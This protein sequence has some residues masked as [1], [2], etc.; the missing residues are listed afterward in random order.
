MTNPWTA[1]WEEAEATNPPGVLTYNTLELIH[2]AFVDE[3]DGPFSI[4]AVSGVHEDMSFGLELGAPL[5]SGETVLF[6]AINFYSQMPEFAE[7]QT[8]SCDIII[9]NVGEEV[10]PY[11]EAAVGT[12]ANLTTIWRQY[13]SDDLSEPCYGPITFQIKKVKATLTRL[14]G[15]AMLDNLSNR[16]FPNKLFT[17]TD[18]PGLL[19]Q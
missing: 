11:L 2:P 3:V 12:R 6:R 10:I 15:T 8:P 19:N 18:F 4:R 9:D 13:R 17:F 7:G 1:A 14:Q 5:N 16:K